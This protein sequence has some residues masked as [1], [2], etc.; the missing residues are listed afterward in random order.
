MDRR[1][2]HLRLVAH[3]EPSPAAV[4]EKAERSRR[5][6]LLTLTASASSLTVLGLVMVLSASSVSAFT[7]YGSSFMFFK[8]QLVYAIV[9]AAAAAAAARVPH[10][11]WQRV[12]APLM[13]VSF[14]LLVLVLH[15][16]VGTVAGGSSRWISLGW[17]AVQPSEFAKFAIVCA[18]AAILARNM[19][20]LH[21]PG[22]W[23]LPLVP[24]VT[25]LGVLVMLQP[26]LGTTMVI[27]T[28]VFL[29]LF[30][31]GVR[32]RILGVCAVL[33]AGAGLLLVMG[34][35]YRRTRFL[36]FLNPWADPQSTGYQ[37]IQSLI[38]LGSGQL[39]GVGLGASRQ[40]WMYVPNAHTDFIF[41]I[42]GEELG[43]VGELV[44]LALFGAIVYSG[45][46]IALRAP[47]S[48]GRLLAAGITG[49]IGTQALVNLG[50]VTGVLPITGVPLPFM[51]FG[52]SSLVVS[53][54]AVGVLVSIGRAGGR[55]AA[56]DARAR[57]GRKAPA[58]TGA[59]GAPPAS[60]SA[61]RR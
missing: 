47:D 24:L 37:I 49:W 51:S 17:F 60:G 4:R 21:E 43:L 48:F 55:P 44:V 56:A 52:G 42:M 18:A 59:R 45:V 20:Y 5:R 33:T 35:G 53:L 34:E 28:T 8:R 30:V 39:I 32:F 1:G 25:A 3:G 2:S 50:A 15:P 29:V 6:L 27:V 61:P 11:F 38:A 19:R 36:S 40:K 54:A 9:G 41:S 46:R 23:M 7:Q 57:H 13:G 31:A 22:R 12:W 14:V 16:S 58:R 26:D 10:R